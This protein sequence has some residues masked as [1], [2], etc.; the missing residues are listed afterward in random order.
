MVYFAVHH[1]FVMGL[2]LPVADGKY[3]APALPTGAQYG[4]L[5]WFAP[6]T[7]EYPIHMATA[8]KPENAL[9]FRA[10]TSDD[11]ADV[12]DLIRECGPLDENSMYCNLI[13]CD[14]FGDTCVIAELDGE[15][16]GWVSAFIPP[17]ELDTLFVWQVAVGEKAR[18]MGVAR[19]MLTHLLERECCSDVS[20]LK[21]T[22]TKDNDASWAL[23]NSFAGRLEA[24]LERE[25]HYEE[26]THFDGRHA[27]EY[28]VTIA[29]INA[30]DCGTDSTAA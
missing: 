3:S 12:W 15:I 16:V 4:I 8:S 26:D 9:T 23:F 18:G 6:T 20:K 21:T 30:S 11:G 7:L 19:K 28:M 10:P 14:Y 25:P 13:Q 27:T 2:G 17:N 24:R 22:I 5:I 29:D 1:I